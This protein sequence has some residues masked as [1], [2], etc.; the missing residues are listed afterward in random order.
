MPNQA[1]MT[2][3]QGQDEHVKES[4]GTTWKKCQVLK[5]CGHPAQN[6]A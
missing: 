6:W 4:R 5:V 3:N 2:K 1:Q